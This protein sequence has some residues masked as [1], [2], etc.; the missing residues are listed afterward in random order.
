MVVY[1][2]LASSVR[3]I[4]HEAIGVAALVLPKEDVHSPSKALVLC[5]KEQQAT[6][7]SD[8]SLVIIVLCL[9][10]V[11]APRELVT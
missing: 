9:T 8:I 6:G 5:W 10:T 1:T 3:T 7:K 4:T 2:Y 11:D